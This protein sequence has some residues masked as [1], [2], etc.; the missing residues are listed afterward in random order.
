M[1][2]PGTTFSITAG[3]RC[4]DEIRVVR[5]GVTKPRWIARPASISSAASTISTS[6]GAGMSDS[7]GVP[8][9]SGTIST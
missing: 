1:P 4:V 9:R 3:V 6:P 2:L 8:P 5:S 7:T